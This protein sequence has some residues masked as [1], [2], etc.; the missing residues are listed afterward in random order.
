MF[1]LN[2]VGLMNSDIMMRLELVWVVCMSERC[3]LW[4]VFIVGISLMVWLFC[5]VVWMVVW[6][7][8]IVCRIFMWFFFLCLWFWLVL[9]VWW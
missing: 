6:M 2:C 3:L 9:W 8:V 4:K 1:V 5:W 7:L